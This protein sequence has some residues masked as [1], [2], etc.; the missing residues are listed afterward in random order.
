M[1]YR[2][3]V[4]VPVYNV[5]EYIR[6]CMGAVVPQL[7]DDVQL[8]LVDD[9]STDGSGAI[10][11]EYAPRAQ[12]IHQPNRGV[13]GARNAGLAAAQGEYLVWVDPDDWVAPD[14]MAKIRAG[15]QDAP[16]MLLFDYRAW[17]ND[18]VSECRYGRE[19]GEQPVERVLEDVERDLTLKSALWNKV[20]RREL[21]AGIRFDESLKLLEDYDVLHHLLMRM[22]T[23]VY[24]PELLYEYRIR[25]DGLTCTRGMDVSYRSFLV[26]E[27]RRREVEATG[28]RCNPIGVAVQAKWFCHFYYLD[29]NPEAFRKEFLACRRAIWRGMPGILTDEVLPRRRKIGF[30]LWAMPGVSGLYRR[31]VGKG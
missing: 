19:A 13:A 27:K 9:G 17:E 8:I 4:I 30:A 3:S 21:F 20:M 7:D 18:A 16:D 1:G 10:C 6:Q 15:V 2:F 14:W 5:A 26:A 23:V 11:D 31:R 29:G 24:L 25:A 28:R 22:K 12:V